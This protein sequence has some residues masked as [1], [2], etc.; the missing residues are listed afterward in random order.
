MAELGWARFFAKRL[1]LAIKYKLVRQIPVAKDG[2]PGQPDE[3]G[4]EQPTDFMQIDASKWDAN[5]AVSINVGLGTGSRDRDM[6]MLNNILMGQ[7]G[8]A[9]RLGAAGLTSKAIEF[10]P[11][12][13]NTA[14]RIAESSG[15]KNPEE[16]YPE[17]SDEE[18]EAYKKQAEEAAQQ[19]PIELQLEQAKAQTQMQIEQGKVQAN[20]QLEQMKL[21]AAQQ[22]Q[23]MQSEVQVRQEQAQLEAD[24]TTKQADQRNAVQIEGMKIQSAERIKLAELDLKKQELAQQMQIELL[25]LQAASAE[26]EE[27]ANAKPGPDG[28]PAKA[29]PK[30]NRVLVVDN[31]S[32][33]MSGLNTLAQGMER[34]S[35]HLTAPTEIVRGEDGKAIGTRKVVN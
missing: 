23:V 4:I 24:M 11:K 10:I 28:K 3:N 14:V 26:A 25:K 16:Y 13:R 35:A 20:G 2:D 12:I 22:T 17:V 30:G 1:K 32:S 18:V 31:S 29:K 5:M 8:M 6:A 21:Q 9:D 7:I 34:L 15:L 19:P 33:I 27:A